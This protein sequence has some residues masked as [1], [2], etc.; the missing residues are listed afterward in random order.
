MQNHFVSGIVQ[1]LCSLSVDLARLKVRF[2]V[3]LNI[4]L[5]TNTLSCTKA[6]VTLFKSESYTC[7]S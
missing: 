2:M 3:N 4:V 5:G 6:A 1:E 7:V